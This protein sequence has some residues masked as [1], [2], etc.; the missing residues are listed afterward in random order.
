[1][2][3]C[4]PRYV[5]TCDLGCYCCEDFRTYS[6]HI[7]SVDCFVLV[8]LCCLYDWSIFQKQ[9]FEV[10]F[11]IFLSDL[12]YSANLS[13]RVS[14][15][16]ARGVLR[17]GNHWKRIPR[18]QFSSKNFPVIGFY[19]WG[20]ACPLILDLTSHLDLEHHRKI[21]D[22]ITDD[23]VVGGTDLLRTLMSCDKTK[24]LLLNIFTR[25]LPNFNCYS[26]KR[27]SWCEKW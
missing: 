15:R 2:T 14:R 5:Q 7:F 6:L 19:K 21:C 23:L 10:K 22:V 1:M 13:P 4:S 16:H 12:L 11:L 17:V 20:D 26:F 18:W 27:Q 8:R 9:S 3:Q 24:S 25:S